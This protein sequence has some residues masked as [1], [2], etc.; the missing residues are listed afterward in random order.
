MS[1]NDY[2]ESKYHMAWNIS[3]NY[4]WPICYFFPR[5]QGGGYTSSRGTLMVL[6]GIIIIIYAV[7]PSDLAGLEVGCMFRKWSMGWH[8]SHHKRTCI[9]VVCISYS[10]QLAHILPDLRKIHILLQNGDFAMILQCLSYKFAKYM[11]KHLQSQ[12]YSTL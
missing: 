9:T 5:F 4:I 6:Y 11:Y 12:S 1:R 3:G 10:A 8:S 2:V 7:F